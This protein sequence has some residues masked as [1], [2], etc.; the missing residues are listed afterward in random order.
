MER[1]DAVSLDDGLATQL[2]S[3]G[4]IYAKYILKERPT[5]KIG[6]LYQNDDY[7]KDYVKGIRDGL[8]AKTASMI[9]GEESYETTYPA[10][11]S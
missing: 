8:G 6:I 4:R 2:P 5:G 11:N 3:E 10:I 1:P 9:I 7:G